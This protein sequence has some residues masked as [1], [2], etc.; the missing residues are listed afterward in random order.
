MTLYEMLD[1]TLYYQQ[2]WIF[3]KNAYDQNMPIFKGTVSEARKNED[4]V[5]DYLMC[6]VDHYECDTG[7]LVIKVRD[8]HFEER[9]EKQYSSSIKWGI[10]REKRP[11]LHSVEISKDLRE[12]LEGKG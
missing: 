1:V 12:A 7:I 4:R 2:T 8:E 6:K 10:K 3:K 5:W 9:L 11:W